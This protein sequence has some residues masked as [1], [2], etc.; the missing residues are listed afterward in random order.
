M[1]HY[2]KEYDVNSNEDQ[3]DT[4]PYLDYQ[5]TED[6]RLNYKREHHWRMMFEDNDGGVDNEKLINIVIDEMST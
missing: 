5:Q 3:A 4:D 2:T 6:V 1:Q